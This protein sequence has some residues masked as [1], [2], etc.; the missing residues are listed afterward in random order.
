MGSGQ[1]GFDGNGG[2][3]V[4]AGAGAVAFDKIE[5]GEMRVGLGVEIG[6]RDP[7]VMT[8]PMRRIADPAQKSS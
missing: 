1:R 4:P 5:I 3:E 2:L 8:A 7:A 6:A